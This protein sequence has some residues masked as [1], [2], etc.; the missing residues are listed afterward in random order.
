MLHRVAGWAMRRAGLA[1]A[2]WLVALIVVTAGAT[3]VGSAYKNTNSLPGTDSQRVIDIFREHQPQ[4]ATDSV[5][6]VLYAGTGLT[7]PATRTRIAGMLAEVG[8]LPHVA[9]VADPFTAKGS[10]SGDGRTAYATVEFDV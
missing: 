2:L 8:H 10:L 4:G 1:V 6:I 9:A 3:L 7:E 5:Q